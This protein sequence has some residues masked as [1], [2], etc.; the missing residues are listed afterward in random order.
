MKSSKKESPKIPAQS[1][2][3]AAGATAEVLARARAVDSQIKEDTTAGK[4]AVAPV[5]AGEQSQE[6]T[7][8]PQRGGARQG[9]GRKP[10]GKTVVEVIPAAPDPLLVALLSQVTLGLTAVAKAKGWTA[11]VSAE[12]KNGEL[13]MSTEAWMTQ[14]QQA[15]IAV[16]QKHCPDVLQKYGAEITLCALVIPW[17]I[18]NVMRQFKA[19]TEEKKKKAEELKANA[20]R[21]SDGGN[22]DD[23]NGQNHANERADEQG[24]A[25][26]AVA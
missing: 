22:R 18:E 20:S 11:P 19:W 26:A 21:K 9:A 17:V 6:T 1:K 16:V 25:A 10:G 14:V 5:M 15:E 24:S 4:P 7:A 23:G 13:K 8:A 3:P 2:K 12:L